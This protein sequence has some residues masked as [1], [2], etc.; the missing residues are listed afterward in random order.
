ML[1]IGTVCVIAGLV[2]C[3]AKNRAEAAEA[4]Q[5]HNV[6]VSGGDS[7]HG[8]GGGREGKQ[9]MDRFNGGDNQH[10]SDGSG[11]PRGIELQDLNVAVDGEGGAAA[12]EDGGDGIRAEAF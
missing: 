10:Q 8:G 7:K 9:D 3:G 2:V 4:D 1:L 5:E 11:S 12:P 6:Y